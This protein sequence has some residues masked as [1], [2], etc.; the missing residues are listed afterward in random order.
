MRIF[1]FQVLLTPVQLYCTQ[2]CQLCGVV[3][4][5]GKSHSSNTDSEYC[6]FVVHVSG[7]RSTLHASVCMYGR[8]RT[9]AEI[10]RNTASMKSNLIV[11]LIVRI[12]GQCKY[13]KTCVA[14]C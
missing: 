8:S 5:Y 12:Q 6:V 3:S 2:F 14:D 4:D 10:I 9:I 7:D 11:T 13:N 1:L